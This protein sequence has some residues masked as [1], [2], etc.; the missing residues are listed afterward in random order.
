MK[1]FPFVKINSQRLYLILIVRFSAA[2]R[3]N[4][5]A[6]RITTLKLI[7]PAPFALALEGL[8][9]LLSGLKPAPDEDGTNHQPA[10]PARAFL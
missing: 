4:I 10:H 5:S 9:C 7:Q 1:L 6:G 3:R 2:Y 8:D